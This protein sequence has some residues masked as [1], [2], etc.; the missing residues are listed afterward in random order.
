MS[1]S[2]NYRE[3]SIGQE[4]KSG[5]KC[6][7]NA[8]EGCELGGARRSHQDADVFNVTFHWRTTT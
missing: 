4:L 8:E 7:A 2:L 6:G 5:R 1:D 3:I